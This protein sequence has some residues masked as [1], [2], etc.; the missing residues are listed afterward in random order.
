V[1]EGEKVFDLDHA[2]PPLFHALMGDGSWITVNGKN[3]VGA[4][5]HSPSLMTIA[6]SLVR[7]GSRRCTA[8][9]A[10]SLPMSATKRAKSAGGS[11]DAGVMSEFH[12]VKMPLEAGATAKASGTGPFFMEKY[13]YT[14]TLKRAAP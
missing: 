8:H 5:W 1:I 12:D 11:K 4:M 6:P 2:S 13:N 3:T 9:R 7:D 10:R 14:L